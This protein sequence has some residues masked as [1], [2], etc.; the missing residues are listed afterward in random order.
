VAEDF[1]V[2]EELGFEPDGTGQHLLLKVLKRHA[3]TE[4]VARALARHA[5][6]RTGDVG[7]AG[8]KDRHAVAIQWFSVPRGSE[9]DASWLEIESAE[10][11]V[12]ESHPHGRKL[13][14]GALAANRFCIRVRGLR[15]ERDALEER[16][17][18]IRGRGVP[19]YF[20]Q[21]RFG[22]A[23]GNLQR[24]ANWANDGADFA[25]R[26]ERSF[27]LSAG[28]S[29]VFNAVLAER[30]RRGNWDRLLNGEIVNLQGS[31]S[32]FGIDTPSDDLL[33]RCAEFDLHPTGPMWGRGGLRPRLEAAEPEAK[34]THEFESVT[35]ALERAGLE[36]E[37][38]GLRLKVEALEADVREDLQVTFRLRAGA[39]ATAVLREI[40]ET[41]SEGATA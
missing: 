21:Q 29:L 28:R 41:D 35:A 2:E 26:A 27:T 8:L 5:R 14:R 10:F 37:R 36:Y 9:S 4:W 1:V 12:L 33:R 40:V 24:L 20:G 31:G 3:N 32:V 15:G 7:F 30:V 25:T 38:R 11:K 39:F 17:A 18:L 13:R 19:N 34:V 6:S 22:V 23:G 16:L